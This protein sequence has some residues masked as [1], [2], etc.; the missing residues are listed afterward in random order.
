M[1]QYLCENCVTI[2][3]QF[4]NFSVIYEQNVTQL[5]LL[6]RKDVVHLEVLD[7]VGVSVDFETKEDLIGSVVEE[8]EEEDQ[9]E[10]NGVEDVKLVTVKEE[11][12]EKQSLENSS[13]EFVLNALEEETEN[14]TRSEDTG[15]VSDDSEAAVSNE[16]VV[17][18]V[19]KKPRIIE[20]DGVTYEERTKYECKDCGDTFLFSTGIISHMYKKHEMLDIDPEKYGVKI[21]IKLNK[22]QPQTDPKVYKVQN[23]IPKC[24]ICKQIFET[25]ELLKIHMNVHKTYVCE[26]CGNSFIKKSYLDDHKEIHGSEKNYVC[27]YCNK[28]FQRRTVFVKHKRIHTHPRQCVCELC[29][30]R[31]NDNGT[32]KT[33]RLLIHIKDR[34]FKCVICNQSFALKPTLDK[35][36]RRHMRRE[37]GEKEFT[38]DRCGMKY[39]DKS[40]L[41]R[42]ITSKHSGVALKAQC[43][44]CGKAYTSTTNLLKH[45][46]AHHRVFIGSC[47]DIGL[48]LKQKLPNNDDE[49]IAVEESE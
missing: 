31:F 38:C 11:I 3:T 25:T 22:P 29:G 46:R 4:Y 19:P 34:K 9:E 35:H 6:Q 14:V 20:K 41:N 24:I 2:T 47:E 10:N 42:H 28:C 21:L 33:H 7:D 27:K 44:L 37:N 16:Q 40:S 26:V 43:E 23:R 1:P 12:E 45:K 18:P 49:P 17:Y 13:D 36:I 48:M 5:K 15:V 30:K 8:V 32:L 39:R